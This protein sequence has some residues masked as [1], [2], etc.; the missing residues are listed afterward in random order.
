V[1]GQQQRHKDCFVVHPSEDYVVYAMGSVVVVKSLV[2]L[3]H[4]QY[5][6]GHEGQVCVITVSKSGKLLGTG[7]QV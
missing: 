5:L 1:I 4:V 6:K 2:D 7:E 3:T